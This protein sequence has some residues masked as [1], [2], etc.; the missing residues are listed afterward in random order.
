MTVLSLVT[1]NQCNNGGTRT[2]LKCS[3]RLLHIKQWTWTACS[4]WGFSAVTCV[5]GCGGAVTE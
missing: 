5:I 3:A 2:C 1:L 4:A